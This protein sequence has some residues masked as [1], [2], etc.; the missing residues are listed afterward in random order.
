M[1]TKFLIACFVWCL[2]F[3]LQ[4]APRV[5]LPNGELIDSNTDL[6]VKVLGGSVSIERT[7]MNGRWYLNPAWANLKFKRDRIDNTIVTY[8]DRAGSV[9]ELLGDGVVYQFDAQQFIRREPTSWV[10][11]DRMGNTMTYDDNGV[12]QGYKNKNGVKVR[13]EHNSSGQLT[14]VFDHFDTQVL[15]VSYSGTVL[16]SI[17]DYTGRSV[18]YFYD[19]ALLKEFRDVDDKSYF[20]TY[21]GDS[22]LLTIK[23]PENRITKITY[24]SSFPVTGIA[25][26]P[27]IGF[28]GRAGRDFR[29]SR[30]GLFENAENEKTSYDYDFSR[31]G[32]IFTVVMTTPEQRKVEYR[33][34]VSGRLVTEING[35]VGEY[36]RRTDG[37]NIE[38]VKNERGLITRYEYDSY[39]NIINIEHPNNTIESWKYLPTFSY[40]TEYTDPMGIIRRFRYNAT[41]QM[42]EMREAVGLPEER[43]ETYEYDNFGRMTRETKRA[44]LTALDPEKDAVTSYLYDNYGNT[45]RVTD[46]EGNIIKF[47]DFDAMGNARRVIDA[48]NKVRTMQYSKQG[49]LL[50]STN[51]LGFITE[52]KYNFAGERI[53]VLEPIEGVRKA[54]TTYEYDRVGRLIKK[55]DPLL[56]EITEHYDIEGKLEWSKDQRLV[57]T[58]LEYDSRGRIIKMI[59]GNQNE[60]ETVYGDNSNALEGLVAE[61]KYPTY[62]ESYK[63]DNID[64]QTEVTQVLSSTL[65]YTSKT[66]YDS[67]SNVVALVDAKNRTSLRKF[68]A[69]N[70]LILEIDHLLGRTTFSYDERDNLLSVKDSKG[71]TNRFTYDRLNRKLTEIR[72]MGQTVRYSYDANSN[73]IEYIV[74]SGAKRQFTYDD[75]NRLIMEEH[76][77]PKTNTANKT[78]TYSYDQ[79]GLLKTYDDGLTSGA[80]DYNDKGEK[81]TEAITF[82][83]GANA[84]TKTTARTY[85]ANGLLRSFTYPDATGT[86]NFSYD[87]NNQLKTYKIPGLATGNDTLTYQYRWNAVREITMPGR[88]KRTVVLDELQRPER[89]EVKGYGPNP[90]N[91]G[92]PVMDHRYQYDEVS[93]ILKKATLDGDYVYQYDLLDRLVS[94]KPPISLQLGVDNPDGLPQEAYN[95][96]AVHNR[97]TSAHQPGAWLYNENNE[98]TQWGQSPKLHKL[99]YDLNGSTIKDEAGNP[100]IQVTDYIYDAQVRLVEVKKEGASLAKYAYDPMGRRIRREAGTETTWFLYSDEGLIEELTAANTVIRTYGWNP[101]GMWGTDTVWQKDTNGIFIAHNDHLFTTDVLTDSTNGVNSWNAIRES[102]GK[103]TVRSGSA[104]NYLMRFP[105]QWEDQ[106]IGLNQNFR[107][108]YSTSTAFYREFD[109]ST[110]LENNYSYVAAA[111]TNSF[112]HLG[113]FSSKLGFYIH[114]EITTEA[115]IRSNWNDSCQLPWG[116][117]ETIEWSNDYD[118]VA[119]SQLIEN[120]HTHAMTQGQRYYEEIFKIRRI[121]SVEQ[122]RQKMMAWISE[123]LNNYRCDHKFLGFALHTIQDYSAGG[124]GFQPWDGGWTTFAIPDLPHILEDTFPSAERRESAVADSVIAINIWVKRCHTCQCK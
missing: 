31:N 22:Q 113:L 39:R 66:T 76:Y 80:Y 26:P 103:T 85:E 96:D 114:K 48:R 57:R 78:M 60:T 36:D 28:S 18:R 107:R 116:K 81:I 55:T 74:P 110:N 15:T 75:E 13:L 40:I 30:V 7:W 106:L 112:D 20:Y 86:S 2:S 119:G 64:R 91:N 63:Y 108:N 3:V 102:F 10:W 117:R 59:D 14:G 34:D 97:T 94:A 68:D 8:V 6:R 67:N 9:Y 42:I 90:G 54:K 82:G 27:G 32:Q 35:T 71:N 98:L 41:G 12:M 52:M 115:I 45:T 4:A 122:A 99:T 44:S 72:P 88:L 79:R 11:F 17:S 38:Y 49:W 84:F 70:R 53:E 58:K 46:A 109:P 123:N 73:L 37:P 118:K 62:T 33:Y 19:A 87:T 93:N 101:D 89:I 51:A 69:L 25:V 43:M 120:S 56:G 47:E 5:S 1:K 50:K 121:E 23:D 16:N 24:A 29:V 100:T 77:S 92:Q 61:R 105:G 83:K 65:S 95:Y 111:P 104:T 21:N 124:H